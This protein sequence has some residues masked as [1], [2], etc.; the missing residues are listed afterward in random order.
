MAKKVEVY[1]TSNTVKQEDSLQVI[2]LKNK[3]LVYKILK[4]FSIED[5]KGRPKLKA[6]EPMSFQGIARAKG[7]EDYLSGKSGLYEY[8]L[9]LVSPQTMEG[10]RSR[11]WSYGTEERLAWALPDPFDVVS[12][13]ADYH[14]VKFIHSCHMLEDSTGKKLPVGLY[15]DYIKARMTNKVYDIKKAVEIL[16]KNPNIEFNHGRDKDDPIQSVPYYNASCGNHHIGF[17][18]APT[19]REYRRMW[20]KCLSYG[21]SSYPSTHMERAIWDLDLLGLRKGKAA[22]FKDFY[23]EEESPNYDYDEY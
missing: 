12:S 11:G 2:R 21:S 6:S 7:L 1:E 16:E 23:G 18:W 3:L 4:T 8:D 15:L 17:W 9:S 20:K 10:L 14:V 19:V 5:R 13:G 22:K